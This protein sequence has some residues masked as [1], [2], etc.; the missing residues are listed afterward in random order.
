MSKDQSKCD[1]YVTTTRE[2]ESYDSWTGEISYEDVEDS[3]STCVDID[4]HHYK[5]TQCGYVGCYGSNF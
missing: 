3:H 4:L 1:H 5:C 2:V